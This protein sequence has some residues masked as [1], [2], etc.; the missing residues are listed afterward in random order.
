VSFTGGFHPLPRLQ[1]ALALPLGVEAGGEWFD[2]EFSGSV[3]PTGALAQLQATLPEGLVLAGVEEVPVSAPS[4]SQE[5]EGA[6]W[7][8][9]LVAVA[10]G[11]GA[12]AWEPALVSL[13]T[14]AELPWSDTDKKGRPRQRD[15]RPWL[16]E[17]TLVSADAESCRFRLGARIDSQGRSLRPEQV[18]FWLQERLGCALQLRHVSRERLRL[19]PAEPGSQEGPC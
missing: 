2:L 14:A 11:P 19:R 5:L 13:L 6:E 7:Q 12:A 10:P 8:A 16:D 1:F 15:C 18:R 9:E 4:L 3:D 17:L